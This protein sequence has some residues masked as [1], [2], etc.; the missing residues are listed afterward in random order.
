MCDLPARSL[1]FCKLVERGTKS[2]LNSLFLSPWDSINDNNDNN[3]NNNNNNNNS[4]RSNSRHELS[5]NIVIEIE[6]CLHM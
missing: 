1:L 5:S 3:D 4:N 6:K 2:N